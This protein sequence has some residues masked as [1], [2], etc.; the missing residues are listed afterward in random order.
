[1][2]IHNNS[3]TNSTKQGTETY[4]C[5]P[6]DEP[7]LFQQ[8][9]QRA[10]LAQCLQDELIQT[11][12]RTNRGVKQEEY[13]VLMNTEMPSAL[14]EI[15]FISNPEEQNLLMSSYFQNLAA[16]AIA[17]GIMEYLGK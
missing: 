12:K 7:E 2:S 15:A 5:A 8:K 17:E 13:T 9:A 11:L 6:I 16:Q 3:T 10:T 4:Y 1:M 14:V